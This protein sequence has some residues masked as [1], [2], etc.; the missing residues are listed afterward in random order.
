[1]R[2][3]R[4][5]PPPVPED[6]R[7]RVINR[8]HTEAQKKRKDAKAV[9]R[10]KKILTHE[11]LDKRRCQQRKDGLPLEESPSP[12]IS[13]DASDRDDEDKMGRGPL[14]HL[15]DIVEVVPGVLAS[16]PALLGGGG[17]D[18][19]LA[20]ARSGAEVDMPEVRALGKCAVS[21]V[22]SAAAVEQV[23]AEATQLPPQR[24]EGAPGSFEDQPAPMDTEAMPLPPPLPLRT[25]VAMAKRLPPRSSRKRPAEVPTL[26]PLKALKVNLGSTAHWVAE[27]QAALHHGAASAR[28][29]PKEPATQ[30]GAIEAALTQEG[31]AA[32]PPRDSE[33]RGSDAAEV[34]LA[35]ET[36]RTEVPRV[37]QARATETTVPETIEA[38][39]AG[40][41]ALATAEATMAEAGAP[42]T[43]EATMAK[44]GAP[45]TT[46]AT[47]VEVGAPGTTDADVIVAGL[48][49]QEVGMKA[50]EALAAPLVQGPPPLRESAREVEVLPISS[51]DTSRA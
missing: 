39:A 28:A 50:V 40:V 7:R 10:T 47:M 34:L 51:D 41:G 36:T 11:E 42:E 49:A 27:A 21:P 9:K 30:G 1:M 35:T 25:R 33:A 31:E 5:S 12:S 20:I 16:S 6:T 29:D 24:T 14:D 17:A 38:D 13:T 46:E 43:T 15:P 2:D 37:S 8:A 45:G 4:A 44:A 48:P 32:P 22:G 3:M 23:A 26:A 19:G 18:L